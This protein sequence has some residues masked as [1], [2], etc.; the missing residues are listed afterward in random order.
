MSS[1]FIPPSSQAHAPKNIQCSATVTFDDDH[2]FIREKKHYYK[3]NLIV[4]CIRPA[5]SIIAL[6]EHLKCDIFNTV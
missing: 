3:Q 6:N 4:D 1:L 2:Y 5:F